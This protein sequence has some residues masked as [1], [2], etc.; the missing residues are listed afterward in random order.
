MWTGFL[1][2]MGLQL[3]D[4]AAPALALVTTAA[5]CAGIRFYEAAPDSEQM[6]VSSTDFSITLSLFLCELHSIVC[7]QQIS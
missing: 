1:N 4:S 5:L 6:T 2:E 3:S 7:H